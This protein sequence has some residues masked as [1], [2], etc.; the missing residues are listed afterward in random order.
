[1]GLKNL[2]LIA[3]ALSE[4]GMAADTPAAVIA[5]ATTGGQRVVVATLATISDEAAR[6]GIEAPALIVIGNIVSMR[7]KLGGG[8]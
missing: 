1:M 6:Q 3:A 2:G 5:S 7:E 4:G 8:S